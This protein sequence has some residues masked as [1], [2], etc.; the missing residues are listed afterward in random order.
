MILICI[1]NFS[2]TNKG[3]TGINIC[4][5]KITYACESKTEKK[6]TSYLSSQYCVVFMTRTKSTAD[7]CDFEKMRCLCFGR[8]TTTTNALGHDKTDRDSHCHGIVVRRK[9]REFHGRRRRTLRLPCLKTGPLP[10]WHVEWSRKSRK[11]PHPH[12]LAKYLT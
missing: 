4:C 7:H 10:A 9:L 8:S 1:L 2:K 3:S 12:L 11:M 5:L 6:E